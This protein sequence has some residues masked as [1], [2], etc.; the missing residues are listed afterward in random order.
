MDH[1]RHVAKISQM[2][3]VKNGKAAIKT[4]MKIDILQETEKQIL[5]SYGCVMRMEDCRIAG[6]LAE[7][8]PQGKRRRSRPI[9]I[10][11]D[12]ISVSMQ[13]NLISIKCSGIK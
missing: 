6:P 2:Y 9:N 4:G 10:W 12:W 11:Q 7:W 1:L 8:K 5:R 13:R 3:G